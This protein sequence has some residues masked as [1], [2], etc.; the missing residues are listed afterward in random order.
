MWS[1][2]EPAGAPFL[3]VLSKPPAP[4]PVSAK[5]LEETLT[6]N[7]LGLT[8]SLQRTLRSANPIESMISVVRDVNRNVKRWRCGKMVERWTA[9][10]MLE[11]ENRFCRIKGYRDL[12]L[13]RRTLDSTLTI[14][15]TKT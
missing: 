5:G 2:W 6:V 4:P 9:A 14:P 13:L 11:A 10:G 8:P 12:H 7:R 15:K 1:Q 3:G